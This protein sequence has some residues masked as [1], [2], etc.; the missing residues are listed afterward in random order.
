MKVTI[1]SV[2]IASLMAGNAFAEITVKQDPTALEPITVSADLRDI[3]Q[4]KIAAS[5]TILNELELQDRG[6][7]HFGDVLL[8][9]PNVNFSAEGSRPRH[10]QIRGMGERDEYTG[11]PNASV[12]F[13]IDDIDFSGIGMAANLFDIKQVE[14]LRGPQSTRYGANA[15]AGLVNVQSN[16]PTPYRESMLE[17]TAGQDDLREI[18][19]MTSGAFDQSK[20]DSPLYRLSLFKHDSDGFRKNTFLGKDD[21]NQ[22][23]ELYVR[24]KLHFT[25]TPSTM[26]DLTILHADIDNGYDVWTLDN[27]FTT[28][29]DQPGKDKQRSTAA[30]AKFTVD[31]SD[32]F[33]LISTTTVAAS[34]LTY[35]YDGDWVD[36]L[37][38]GAANPFV[39]TYENKKQRDTFT[40]EFRFVSKPKSRL[41]NNSTDW[42]AGVYY[43][44]LNEDN[45]TN[46][47]FEDDFTSP[48]FSTSK[49][50]QFDANNIALFGQLD[51]HI[52]DHTLLSGGVRV[53]RNKQDFS[54]NLGDDFSPSDNLIGGHVS[55]S[56][57]I[58]NQHNIYGSISRGYKAG[59]FNAGLGIG[60]GSQFIQF[61]KE[62][63]WNY[64]LG[65]K[66]SLF[67][68]TLKSVISL[69]YM[70]RNDPQ[71]DGYSFVNSNYVFFTEN[72]DKAENYGVEAEFD[73]QV[74]SAWR[75]FGSLGLLQTKV[76][77]QPINTAFV[78]S[79]R[80]QAHAP[81]Y[82]FNLGTQYRA[83]T[84]LF[85]RI[86]VT[87]VDAFYYD[88]VHNFKSQNYTLTNARIGYEIDKWEVYLW[89]K[90]LFDQT[91]TTRGF[92]FANDPGFANT[93]EFERL[94]DPRQVGVTARMR[95]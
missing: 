34:D 83:Q 75:V 54:S 22:R 15:F 43:S 78:M 20:S 86:D 55:L 85:A 69:F 74:T 70:D 87:G 36:R 94:G 8:Q 71:F 50:S 64:E 56:Y 53:E 68:N 5:V 90:N 60:T 82:Q 28:E 30:A 77:G 39:Y 89:A 76:E 27:D 41:F 17:V 24:G 23:D 26:L 84:G 4:D 45:I 19:L 42:L 52:N 92:V 59:G 80:D 35:S 58:N 2:A 9:L 7:T 81:N 67:D 79:G 18:G 88:N 14:V 44:R 11:A 21:T 38:W 37:F 51:H 1:L 61:N 48:L 72:L 57:D 46:E 33:T 47:T 63:A 49:S 29:T 3:S 40:Q 73:W 13:A 6:A 25:L 31:G 66:S 12:G 32:T 16:D 91:Y 95:F 10:L 93:R 62:T 65:L